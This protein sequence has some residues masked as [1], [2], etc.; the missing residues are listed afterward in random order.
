MPEVLTGEY[1]TRAGR[2]GVTVNR[3][4]TDLDRSEYDNIGRAT[5]R[6]ERTVCDRLRQSFYERMHIRMYVCTYVCLHARLKQQ[7]TAFF[8]VQ[9]TNNTRNDAILQVLF[10]DR[11]QARSRSAYL[12][13]GIWG[14]RSV[15]L[16]RSQSLLK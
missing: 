15:R 10:V 7:G 8:S 2:H 13:P 1:K 12:H 11:E 9:T 14:R 3:D 16:S 5:S 4:S 6:R